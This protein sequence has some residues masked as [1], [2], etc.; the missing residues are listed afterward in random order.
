MIL[1][2]VGLAIEDKHLKSPQQGF[3]KTVNMVIIRVL[4]RPPLVLLNGSNFSP[5]NY[6]IHWTH[7]RKLK[8]FPKFLGWERKTGH[9]YTEEQIC[10][11]FS[12]KRSPECE[13]FTK[14]WK[15]VLRFNLTKDHLQGI[16]INLNHLGL[17]GLMLH[18]KW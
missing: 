10:P 9:N 2:L 12:P 8:K 16:A 11:D 4:P 14:E 7:T 5:R 3:F 18:F 15:L 13:N 17:I 1:F 6:Q